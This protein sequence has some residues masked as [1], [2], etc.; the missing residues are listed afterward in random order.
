VKS[1]ITEKI[2]REFWR[3]YG[4][5]AQPRRIGWNEVSLGA[6]ECAEDKNPEIAA[7]VA[8]LM[9]DAWRFEQTPRFDFASGVL[10]GREVTFQAN[11]GVLEH[12]V[13]KGSAGG[14][15]LLERRR[16]DGFRE[17][18][19][20]HNVHDWKAL[21]ATG[22]AHGAKGAKDATASDSFGQ[23]SDALV[24]RIEAIFPRSASES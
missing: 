1:E 8:E 12:L 15:V 18:V 19:K 20:L 9:S 14:D 5:G 4:G 23:V 7:G 24:D 21:F 11:R 22:S 10:G 17:P 16:Q 13:V 3:M 2:A 6:D